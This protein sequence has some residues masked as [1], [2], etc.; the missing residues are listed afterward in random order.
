MVEHATL[1]AADAQR[2]SL[3]AAAK[4]ESTSHAKFA[5]SVAE[6]IAVPDDDDDLT[7]GE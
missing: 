5:V 6:D 1:Q 4:S 2:E 7:Q 3:V